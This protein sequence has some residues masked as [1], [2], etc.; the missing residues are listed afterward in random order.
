MEIANTLYYWDKHEGLTMTQLAFWLQMRP[1][2]HLLDILKEMQG[3]GLLK[4]VREQWRPNSVRSLWSLTSHSE[5][6][7]EKR[8]G[9]WVVA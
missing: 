3:E 7:A 5:K 9:R 6:L 8:V 2:T 4:S 1:S